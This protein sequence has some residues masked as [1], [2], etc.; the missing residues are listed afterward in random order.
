M[1]ALK[2]K[3]VSEEAENGKAAIASLQGYFDAG[4]VMEKVKEV[5]TAAAVTSSAQM[6]SVRDIHRE[7]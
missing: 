5:V 2:M 3:P 4:P 6:V 1:T 7:I